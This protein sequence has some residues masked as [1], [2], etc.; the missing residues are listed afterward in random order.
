MYICNSNCAC[1]GSAE[2]QTEQLYSWWKEIAEKS[3]N[4]IAIKT[5]LFRISA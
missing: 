2:L 5:P 1:M 3:A 4:T